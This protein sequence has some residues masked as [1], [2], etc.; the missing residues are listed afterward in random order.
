M[1]VYP[2]A[3]HAVAIVK[4]QG[5]ARPGRPQGRPGHLAHARYV[6]RRPTAWG[7]CWMSTGFFDDQ[8][9]ASA[10]KAEIVSKYFWSWAKIMLKRARAAEIAYIDLFAGPGRYGSGEKSTPLLVLERAI[11]DEEMRD[12]LRVVLNDQDPG[13]VASLRAAVDEL[14]GVGMLRHAPQFFSMPVAEEI[15]EWFERTR[16]PPSLVFFD[17]WGYKGLSLRLIDAALKDWGSDLIFFFNYNRINMGIGNELVEDHMDALFGRERANELRRQVGGLPP[18]QRE[19]HVVN[20]VGEAL[21]AGRA[22][23]VLP[24]R[25][26][27]PDGARTSHYLFFAC[28]HVRGYALMKEIMYQASAKSEDGVA[29]FEYTPVEDNQLSLLFAYSRPIDALRRMLRVDFARRTLAMKDVYEQHH[30]GKPF[31]KKNYKNI[32]VEMEQAGEVSCQ[33]PAAERRPRHGK[34]TMGDN[35]RVTFPP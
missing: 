23:H 26:L 33:P 35:V 34:P 24:F 7:F 10:I 2:E 18:A 8:T 29:S 30:V 20:A 15:T 22:E 4:A 9:A 17:P 14:D 12:R 3:V 6:A 5:W 32:L 16:L 11:A 25:F 1:N 27:T 21:L 28:K 13:H 31:V 19:L